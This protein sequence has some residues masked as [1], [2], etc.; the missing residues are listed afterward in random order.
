MNGTTHALLVSLLVAAGGCAVGNAYLPNE[1][2]GGGND[3]SGQI[4]RE[5]W[6]EA[7]PDTPDDIRAAIL[8]GVFVEGMTVEHRDVIS[9][10]DRR[11]TT[12]N[13]YWRSRDLGDELRYEWYVAGE[14]QTFE[15][16]RR[17]SVCE[18]V[19]AEERLRRVRYCE[20]SEGQ[21][22]SQGGAPSGS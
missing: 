8:E 18:L 5:L 19:Y 10:P 3:L 11:G 20:A 9:N 2:G 14:R 4:D 15:D 13:G 22:A 16:G 1:P 12:G 17:R 7:H 6:V 21:D